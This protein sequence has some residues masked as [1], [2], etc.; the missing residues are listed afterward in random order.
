MKTRIGTLLTVAFILAYVATGCEKTPPAFNDT[1]E[2]ISGDAQFYGNALHFEW[3]RQSATFEVVTETA[4]GKWNAVSPTRDIWCSF[5]REGNKLTVIVAENRGFE[6]RST[7]IEFSLGEQKHRI[8]VHQRGQRLLEFVVGTTVAISAPQAHI[9][10]ELNTNIP[11]SD[12][13]VSLENS[14]DWLTSLALSSN[15][16]VFDVS[17]NTSTSQRHASIKVSGDNRT[18]SIVVTQ[19]PAGVITG[20]DA[21]ICPEVSVELSISVGTGSYQWYKDGSPIGGATDATYTATASGIYTVSY[22][23]TMSPQKEVTIISCPVADPGISLTIGSTVWASVNVD[24]FQIFAERADMFTKFFQWNRPTA[25]SAADEVLDGW[26]PNG[27]PSSTWTINPCPEGWRLPTVAEFTAL[28]EAGG[29]ISGIG[30]IWAAANAKGNAV[31]GRFY[32]PNYATC[33]L[34]GDMTGCIFIPAAGWRNNNAGGTINEQTGDGTLRGRYWSSVEQ[35]A[36]GRSFSFVV[37]ESGFS[38]VN[39]GRGQTIRCVQK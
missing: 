8:D 31:A 2:I 17:E 39:K 12:L 5:L 15:N 18:T 19:N 34:D 4:T 7:W 32:G 25:W 1:F 35:S 28:N 33:R 9:S 11:L 23:G 29:T 38:N 20:S 37:A 3:E 27:D 36:A 13:E 24:E 26:D 16:V 22:G 6:P 14:V 21:N 10:L 30:G